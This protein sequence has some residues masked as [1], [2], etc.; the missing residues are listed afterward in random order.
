MARATA[1]ESSAAS[2]AESPAGVSVPPSA[3][4]PLPAA[5]LVVTASSGAGTSSEVAIAGSVL[6]VNSTFFV[7][8]AGTTV[9]VG[10]VV[11]TA[12]LPTGRKRASRAWRSPGARRQRSGSRRRDGRRGSGRRS[13]STLGRGRA[14][15]SGPGARQ[16]GKG[17]RVSVREERCAPGCT[18]SRDAADAPYCLA[19]R[20]EWGQS[21]ANWSERKSSKTRS[22]GG[23]VRRGERAQRGRTSGR[24]PGAPPGRTG[25]QPE[26]DVV[27][28]VAGHGGGARG[29][30]VP[31]AVR[32]VPQV[33]LPV[34]PAVFFTGW[35]AAAEREREGARLE[36]AQSSARS[37]AVRNPY[38]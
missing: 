26:V 36:G 25:V 33:V 24:T 32:V 4:S 10:P 2:T 34:A 21:V 13:A 16:G 28:E 22:V 12:G 27:R 20:A 6:E 31:R 17:G 23:R 1:A 18:G 19:V 35:V 37:D 7:A 15:H 11:P 3:A 9:G 30:E 8:T 5:A 14:R 29:R 38:C